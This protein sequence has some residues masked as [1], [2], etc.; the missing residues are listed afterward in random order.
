MRRLTLIALVVLTG[1]VWGQTFEV[2]TVKL[3]DPGPRT[4]R[5]IKM[6]GTKRFVAQN[7]T[8]KLLIAAAYDLNAKEI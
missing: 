7:F 5:M 8:V 1:T 2:A 4:G 6:D 3:V